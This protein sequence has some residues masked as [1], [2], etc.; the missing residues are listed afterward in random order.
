MIPQGYCWS[1]SAATAI[2]AAVAELEERIALN[3]ET[4]VTVEGSTEFVT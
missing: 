2:E 4:L 1:S 3:G